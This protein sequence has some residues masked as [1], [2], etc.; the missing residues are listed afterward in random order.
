VSPSR[1]EDDEDQLG[2]AR[3][4]A[5][6]LLLAAPLWLALGWFAL[7]CMGFIGVL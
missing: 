7:H 4:I 5:I 6:S 1:F 2:S 3:S